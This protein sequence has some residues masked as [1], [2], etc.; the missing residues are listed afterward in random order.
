MTP[1]AATLHSNGSTTLSSGITKSLVLDNDGMTV[2]NIPLVLTSKIIIDSNGHSLFAPGRRVSGDSR[3]NTATPEVRRVVISPENCLIDSSSSQ[4]VHTI[5]NSS[6]NAPNESQDEIWLVGGVRSSSVNNE[7]FYYINPHAFGFGDG[8]W[9]VVN[10]RVNMGTKGASGS[11]FTVPNETN[12]RT[13]FLARKARQIGPAGNLAS[14]TITDYLVEYADET[15]GTN[16]SIPLTTA[17][18]PAVDEYAIIWVATTSSSHVTVSATI[19]LM[20][21]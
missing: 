15:T 13:V 4:V 2:S 6:V 7:I 18:T 16:T 8:N 17:W 12:L 21:V 14:T 19:D 11:V 20:R 5:T 10:Y 3:L 1:T 9:K